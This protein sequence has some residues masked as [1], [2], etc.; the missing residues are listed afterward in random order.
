MPPTATL[1]TFKLKQMVPTAASVSQRRI[2]VNSV[3]VSI[4]LWAKWFIFFVDFVSR[5]DLRNINHTNLYK[6]SGE[7][8]C[9]LRKNGNRFL[10]SEIL[11]KDVISFYL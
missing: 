10:F 6:S 2:G 1:Q 11:C 3:C 4:L 9:F 7:E 8:W 5:K